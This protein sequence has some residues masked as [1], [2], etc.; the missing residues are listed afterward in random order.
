MLSLK[1]LDK[2]SNTLAN[3]YDWESNSLESDFINFLQE[4]IPSL[5]N[6]EL[7]SLFIAFNNIPAKE[8]MSISFDY[9]N[10]IKN[11]LPP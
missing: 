5:R 10:F 11:H 6:H 9:H 3:I 2:I 7:R 4:N 8:R 1:E